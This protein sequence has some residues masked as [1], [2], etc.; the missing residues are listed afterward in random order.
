MT[1]FYALWSEQVV[2]KYMIEHINSEIQ[3][4]PSFYSEI[5]SYPC[6]EISTKRCIKIFLPWIKEQELG[7]QNHSK[8]HGESSSGQ[9]AVGACQARAE[10]GDNAKESTD[11]NRTDCYS[12]TWRNERPI[13]PEKTTLTQSDADQISAVWSLWGGDLKGYK[14]PFWGD[15]NVL[16]LYHVLCGYMGV[17]ICQNSWK[18]TF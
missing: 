8:G 16:Y 3:K 9:L 18:C 1:D 2:S 11:K 5:L 15:R 13:H 10:D 6:L 12:A 7:G 14:G 17:Y 4:K